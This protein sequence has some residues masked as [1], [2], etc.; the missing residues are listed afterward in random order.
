MVY[1]YAMEYY[2]VIKQNKI[3]PFAIQTDLEGIMLS[4]VSK[5]EKHKYH[6]VLLL[7]VI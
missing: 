2:T 7:C 4:E 1:I 5:A 6:M 3:L